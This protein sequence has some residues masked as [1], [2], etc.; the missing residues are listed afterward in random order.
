[1]HSLTWS[2]YVEQIRVCTR[3]RHVL[4][5]GKCRRILKV[6]PCYP[7]RQWHFIYVAVCNSWRW[8]RGLCFTSELELARSIHLGNDLSPTDGLLNVATHQVT[9]PSVIVGITGGARDWFWSPPFP[10]SPL[11]LRHGSLMLSSYP[12]FRVAFVAVVA[13]ALCHSQAA[14][15]MS[16]PVKNSWRDGPG[17]GHS[18]IS[19][20][21]LHRRNVWG[22]LKVHECVRRR[23]QDRPVNLSVVE[24]GAG[25]M[26]FEGGDIG[27][28]NLKWWAEIS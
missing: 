12:W 21:V 14:S 24:M 23:R 1:M 27:V 16:C 3:Y 25:R 7:I 9:C 22:G 13:V 20:L 2:L 11:W 28:S 19:G 15:C 4:E 26:L 8:F 10:S 17:E 6:S 18:C 5:E